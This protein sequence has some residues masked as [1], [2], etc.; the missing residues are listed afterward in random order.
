MTPSRIRCHVATC[1]TLGA[2]LLATIADAAIYKA[3]DTDGSTVTAWL[4]ARNDT[5]R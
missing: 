4:R 3:I 5:V 1:L 2:F